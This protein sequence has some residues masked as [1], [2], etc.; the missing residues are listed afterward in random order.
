[1]FRIQIPIDLRKSSPTERLASHRVRLLDHTSRLLTKERYHVG[2][3]PRPSVIRWQTLPI[4]R[5]GYIY[6]D[7]NPIRTIPQPSQQQ[8]APRCQVYSNTYCPPSTDQPPHQSGLSH[9]RQRA[10]LEL[11]SLDFRFRG[12]DG[13]GLH[14]SGCSHAP[15]QFRY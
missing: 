13:S 1:M 4:S 9:S 3:F 14:R 15:V 12:T 2:G 6:L 11:R 5:D 10:R 8:S 7:K